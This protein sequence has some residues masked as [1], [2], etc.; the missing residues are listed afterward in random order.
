MTLASLL[1]LA[2]IPAPGVARESCD[3]VEVNHFYDEHGRLVFDQIIWWD[4]SADDARYNVRAWR[5]VKCPSQLPQRS[6]GGF[7]TTWQ[8]G[9]LFRR[10][11]AKAYH[12]TWTQYD[13]EIAEREVLPKERRKELATPVVRRKP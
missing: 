8:D 9:E 13:P 1:L 6:G 10:V 12:E 2:T 5:L 11:W 4:W 3:L 7:E